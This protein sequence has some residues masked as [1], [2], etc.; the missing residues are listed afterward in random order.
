MASLLRSLY[1]NPL[2]PTPHWQPRCELCRLRYDSPEDYAWLTRQ[3][4]G[5]EDGERP[6]T[7]A[8]MAA[9]LECRTG[10]SITQAQISR[11]KTK[12]LN[13]SLQDAI[14]SMTGH[15]VMLEHFAGMDEGEMAVGYLKLALAKTGQLL[16][17]A[18]NAKAAAP[19]ASSQASV[20]A[21]LLRAEGIEADAAL[22]KVEARLAT[23]R[24]E[25][26]Q[27]D[28]EAKF[29]AWVRAHYPD[30]EPLLADPEKLKA[31][32]AVFKGKAPSTGAAS[33]APGGPP[34]A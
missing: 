1:Q 3:L 19:L 14:E 25:E 10:L 22:K 8:Q 15:L 23:L 24:E 32:L 9:E 12:H 7:Q 5:M 6:L 26:A 29:A 31:L 18:D 27:I 2:L 16:S 21:V 4:T 28:Y 17:E 11:H 20:A 13:P 30:L 34:D 33:C